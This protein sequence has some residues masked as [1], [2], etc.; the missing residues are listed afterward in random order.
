MNTKALS[1]VI[2][3]VLAGLMVTTSVQASEDGYDEMSIL[4]QKEMMKTMDTDSDGKI[5]KDEYMKVSE[6]MAAKKFMMMDMN[7]DGWL[8]EV[9]YSLGT[10][11]S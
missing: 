3:T 10:H 8:S 7:D 2:G 5:T 6:K 9:E 1:V 4:Y 11:D